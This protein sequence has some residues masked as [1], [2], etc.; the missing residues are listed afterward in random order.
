MT[1]ATGF[2]P[3]TIYRITNITQARPGVV[4]LEST[5]LSGSFFIVNGMIVTITGVLGM[6]QLNKQRFNVA[7]VNTNANTFELYDLQYFPVDTTSLN[8]Y[9]SGG[10]INIISY[11]ST[12]AVVG[13]NG[14][15]TTPY[16]PPGLM[17]NTQPIDI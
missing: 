10:E 4:T 12:S 17:Y 9:V 14:Q 13:F 1:S 7:N 6:F 2:P 3:G 5:N 15:V 8:A 11:P 16:I